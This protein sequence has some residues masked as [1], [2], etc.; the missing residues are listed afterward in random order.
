MITFRQLGLA[1]RLGN[2]LH[3]I[4]STIG[5]A[6]ALGESWCFPQWDYEPFFSIPEDWFVDDPYGE[7]AT[8]YVPHM[9]ERAKVYLQ[10]Y[11]L[12]R[13]VKDIVFAALQPSV[14]AQ[15]EVHKHQDYLNLPGPLL[16]MHVRRGDNATSYLRGEEGFH[17]LRPS[18]YYREALTLLEHESLAIFSDDIPWCRQEF[19]DL[20]AFYFVGG[21]SRAK[22]H[23]PEYFTAPIEDWIDLTAMERGDAF[24]MSNSSYS[25]WAAFLS[26]VDGP[27]II[28]PDP[29][30]GPR[31]PYINTDLMFP[32]DWRKLPHAP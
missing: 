25:Y 1:G 15:I 9:D 3:Q 21:S 31:L 28:F 29:F 11:G 23:E 13:D 24:I 2:Q 16:V 26:G 32:P 14:E 4:A 20:D 6:T 5:I 18:S 10:D 19:A 12:W 30:F 7:D 17:P 27:Q 8:N 22:E